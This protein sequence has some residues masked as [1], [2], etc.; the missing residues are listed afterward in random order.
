MAVISF[1]VIYTGE[2]PASFLQRVGIRPGQGTVVRSGAQIKADMLKVLGLGAG[3][4]C[5]IAGVINGGVTPTIY[6]PDNVGTAPGANCL[7]GAN[8]PSMSDAAAFEAMGMNRA[9]A[10]SANN[11]LLDTQPLL[12]YF[13]NL[14]N[15]FGPSLP[16]KISIGEGLALPAGD[17]FTANVGAP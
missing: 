7:I 2:T 15:R 17:I 9:R 12:A 6:G 14:V 16:A 10:V 4:R 5:R 13:T 3:I 11:Y 8:I 1:G